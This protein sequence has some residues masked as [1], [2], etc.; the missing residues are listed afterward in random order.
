MSKPLLAVILRRL[1]TPGSILLLLVL[2][3]NLLFAQKASMETLRNGYIIPFEKTSHFQLIPL[4]SDLDLEEAILNYIRENFDNLRSPNTSLRLFHYLESPGGYHF[5]FEQTYGGYAIY[6]AG[7]KVNTDK[8]KNITS[9]FNYTADTDNWPNLKIDFENDRSDAGQIVK[10][11]IRTKFENTASIYEKIYFVNELTLRPSPAYKIRLR[12]PKTKMSTEIIV[13]ESTQLLNSRFLGAHLSVDSAVKIRVQIYMPDPLTSAKTSYGGN[14]IDDNDN[15]SGPLNAQLLTDSVKAIFD[16][17]TNNYKLKNKHVVIKEGLDAPF[18]TTPTSTTADFIFT[19]CDL[20][21]ESVNAY[22]HITK[23]QEYIGDALCFPTYSDTINVLEVDAHALNNDD[24]SRFEEPAFPLD[25]ANI[26][27]GEGGVDDAEDADVII[28]EYGHYISFQANNTNQQTGER[29]AID[30]GFGDYLAASYSMSIDSFNW[31][32]LFSWDGHNEFWIGRNA[33]SMKYY[34]LDYIGVHWDD[35]EILCSALTSMWP[36]IGREATD[37]LALE[38]VAG[39]GFTS[40]FLDAGQLIYQAAT[41]LIDSPCPDS[42]FID[43]NYV[44]LSLFKHGLLPAKTLVGCSYNSGFSEK[45]N[46]GMDTTVCFE[47]NA[48]IALGG[49]PTGP[50]TGVIYCWAPMRSLNNPNIANP[51]AKPKRTTMYYVTV[52]DTVTKCI[53]SDSVLVTVDTCKQGITQIQIFNTIGFL[54]GSSPVLI[55]I[56][57]G[58]EDVEIELFDM[59]GRSHLYMTPTNDRNY[60]L[61]VP[62]LA[63]GMYIV[64]VRTRTRE[65]FAKL[66]KVKTL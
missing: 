12:D 23:F 25:P 8:K 29:A 40:G 43:L 18:T 62:N 58:S 33:T 61:D 26:L 38:S 20:E 28:H 50:A 49:T 14:Y 22:Y 63:P 36:A 39:W 56:P 10:E 64:R 46:A 9:I 37:R 57:T 3:V 17:N 60:L 24:N 2:Q 65:V 35:G 27:F 16:T 13:K 4:D 66:I 47:D 59:M 44:Y 7:I 1:L 34:P 31:D 54:D 45:I 41:T 19:R 51:V 53:Q 15:C 52:F 48:V 55:I 5:T 42:L 32:S 21:F 11:F 6:M 30:E